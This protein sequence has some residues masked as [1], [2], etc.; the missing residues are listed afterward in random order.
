MSSNMGSRTEERVYQSLWHLLIAAVGV[1]EYRH[2]KSKLSKV[3]SL[4][5]IFFHADGAV[6]DLLDKKPLS[7]RILE[8]VRPDESRRNLW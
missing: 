7:R 6:A 1:Y 2:H 8:W 5:L 3:L 4:G